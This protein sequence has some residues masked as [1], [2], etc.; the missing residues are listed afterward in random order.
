MI[1][2]HVCI[3][4]RMVMCLCDFECVSMSLHLTMSDCLY[5]SICMLVYMNMSSVSLSAYMHLLCLRKYSLLS[6]TITL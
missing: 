6:I 4:L 2:Y 5:I 3:H 1:H